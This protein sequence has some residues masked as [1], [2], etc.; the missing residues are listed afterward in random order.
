M[1]YRLTEHHTAGGMSRF[2]SHLSELQPEMFVEISPELARELKI[3]N[4]DY[5]CIVSLR[6]AIEARALVSRRIRPLQLNGKTLHQIAVPYHFG[7]AGLVHGSAANDLLTISG[8]PNVTIMEAKA[9]TCNIVPGRLPLGPA[10][11]GILIKMT[12][13]NRAND[14]ASRRAFFPKRTKRRGPH[15][16][17]EKNENASNGRARGRR[18]R[19]NSE[20]RVADGSANP[21]LPK[22]MI[23]EGTKSTNQRRHTYVRDNV[24]VGFFTDPTVCIGCKA[25]EV[26]CKEWN[27]VPDDGFVWSGN[28]YD[29]TG[30]LGASTWRHVMFVEQ[31]PSKKEA[32][33]LVRDSLVGG[34]G[35][36]PFR[37]VFLSDV[38]KHCEEA[39][40]L[41]ACPTGSIVRTEVGSVLVQDDVCNGCGYCVVSCPFGVIDRRPEPL[42]N[43]G[44]AFKCTF[45]Y[46]RQKSGL[47]PACAK[48]CPTESIVFGRLDDLRARGTRACATVERNGYDDA[49]LYD[50]TETSVRGI[51]AFF[52]ILGEPEAYG[53]PPKPQMPTIYLKSA[54]T[55]AIARPRSHQY[56]QTLLAL[57]VFFILTTKSRI[58]KH[59]LD[60]LR[61]PISCARKLG[62]A[63]LPATVSTLQA[64]QFQENPAIMGEPVVKPPVWTWEVPL[65]FFF[66]GIG[67][68]SA[69]IASAL[70]CFTMSI[71]RARPCGSRPSWC[72]SF[73]NSAD[74]GSWPSPSLSQHA[75]GFQTSIAHVDGRVDPDGF[76]ACVVPGLIAL[77]LHASSDFPRHTGSTASFR[78]RHFRFWFGNFRGFARDL[79]RRAHRGDGDSGVVFASHFAADPFWNGGIGICRSGLEL[80]GHRL[81][82]LN[83]LGFYA[84]G[85]ETGFLIWLSMDKHGAA[86]RAIHEHSSG[87]LIRIGEV[88]NGPLALILRFFGW[89]RLQR[90]H[91]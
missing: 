13:A 15:V 43:A 89:F 88:L 87:W 83:F 5:I 66:G 54:W 2:L 11:A 32:R 85:V 82:V 70:L 56:S 81:S 41:E 69:V 59:R 78:C 64:V 21:S 34:E 67:G 27:H 61:E 33:S 8:E 80:F 1:T 73:T 86:D 36:D 28:S 63:L 77:E 50:P 57:R 49:Q 44:G 90:F 17:K 18:A 31:D 53:L 19:R 47:V 79:H 16:W 62:K 38:C 68:M 58:R 60:E 37:W 12:L 51:D 65:Y 7:T 46:Y 71:L 10:F 20:T 3:K 29:N 9:L 22:A 26:A 45:C 91:F 75:A 42:P 74:H 84:A 6:A 35:E 52:L 14:L 40:C 39:G 4:G 48:V 24:E 72:D 23:G 25:C 76:G 55:S 30:H